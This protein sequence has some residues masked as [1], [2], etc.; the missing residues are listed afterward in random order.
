[1]AS[2]SFDTLSALIQEFFYDLIGRIS[3]GA[4][5]CLA[6]GWDVRN[7]LIPFKDL[8]GGVLTLLA[9]FLSYV[10]G[11]CLD[12]FSGLTVGNCYRWCVFPLLHWLSKKDVYDTDVWQVIRGAR[13]NE[14]KAVLTKMMAERAMVRNLVVL[15][16]GLWVFGSSLLLSLH[17]ATKAVLLITLVAISYR[18][19][20]NCR[21]EA[22]R[23]TDRMD[24]ADSGG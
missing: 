14:R 9:F 15:W 5:L 8:G 19:E 21:R 20:F 2:D 6:V 16:I 13:D 1:M 7:D 10:A 23:S 24:T 12:I 3:P 18:V 17:F 4:L 22:R 11:F